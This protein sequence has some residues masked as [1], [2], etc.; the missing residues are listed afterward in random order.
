MYF[1]FNAVKIDKKL[2][3]G[4][5]GKIFVS[6]F[7]REIFQILGLHIQNFFFNARSLINGF[8]VWR[9]YAISNEVISYFESIR[10][11]RPY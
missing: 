3:L 8:S 11:S 9:S 6:L 5:I 2:G 4:H 7:L 10:H 1:Q